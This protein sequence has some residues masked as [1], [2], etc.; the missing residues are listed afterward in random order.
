MTLASKPK[1]DVYCNSLGKLTI[2]QKDHVATGG[3][4]SVF[5][6]PAKG[7]AVKIFSD[8]DLAKSHG[9]EDKVNL[10]SKFGVSNDPASSMICYPK[11][12]V[13][14]E[15]QRLAGYIMRIVTGI[16]LVKTFSN[17]WRDQHGFDDLAAT[18]LVYHMREALGFA[19][20]QG[21]L[22]VDGNEM[23]YLVNTGSIGKPMPI[24]IDVDSWAIGPHKATAIMMSI[25]DFQ[26]KEFSQLTD[27]FS[28]GIV[29]FQVF[30][31][32]HPF[33]GSNPNFKKADLEGRMRANA[34]VFDP[35]TTVNSAV[36]DFKRIP[37]GL[38]DWFQATFQQGERSIPPD[39]TI[40]QTKAPPMVTRKLK[41]VVAPTGSVTHELIEILAGPVFAVNSDGFVKAQVSSDRVVFY[42][43]LKKKQYPIGQDP[44]D[45]TEMFRVGDKA[46]ILGYSRGELSGVWYDAHQV[47]GLPVKGFPGQYTELLN[48]ADRALAVN[49]RDLDYGLQSLDIV[50]LG[51]NLVVSA[52]S[53]WPMN[54]NS[55]TFYRGVGIM[56]V[57]GKKWYALPTKTGLEVKPLGGLEG[58][59]V[60]DAI[61]NPQ[62][63]L[64]YVLAL[65][66]Q[67]GEYEKILYSLQSDKP[68]FLGTTDEAE[69]NAAIT[70]TGLVVELPE[71]GEISIYSP[72][73]GKS[74]VVKDG[75]IKNDMKLFAVDTGIYYYSGNQIHKL[76]VK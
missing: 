68:E 57:L 60:V 51:P 67:T 37:A 16:P 31:G 26:A 19:H 17:S 6:L 76:S 55:T 24:M 2:T 32:I 33:K 38:L 53:K 73:A 52:S 13:Y 7:I 28:W 22:A 29:S 40:V 54:P 65:N 63:G 71:D 64:I 14:D 11:E 21:A 58:K 10:L 12:N 5:V 25:R 74:K 34:S 4:G 35:S 56:D 23:N 66:R 69:L 75:T 45:K 47:A 41:S 27:W 46:V 61:G 49:P 1:F 43:V 50:A 48:F 70:T 44:R 39:P 62:A 3:E 15:N 30:T 9:M 20:K 8:P 59:D 72:K 36:R 42:D 18:K